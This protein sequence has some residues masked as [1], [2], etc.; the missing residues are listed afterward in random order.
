MQY[1]ASKTTEI[2]LVPMNTAAGSPHTGIPCAEK[3]SLVVALVDAASGSVVWRGW[4]TGALNHNPSEV[5]DQVKAAA[6]KLLESFP[7]PSPRL[8]LDARALAAAHARTERELVDAE[9]ADARF[10]RAGGDPERHRR[11]LRAVHAAAARGEGLLDL[12]PLVAGGGARA[13]SGGER[14]PGPSKS[15]RPRTLPRA[16]ITARSTT[17]CSSRMLPGHGYAQSAARAAFVDAPDRLADRA[18]VAADP[19]LREERDVVRPL[20]QRGH[21]DREDVEAEEE[22]G[23]ELPLARGLLQVAVGGRDHPRVRAERLAAAHPLEFAL[24]EDAQE[25]RDHRRGKLPRLVEEDRAPGC[26]PR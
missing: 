4:A 7:P 5:A 15:P 21:A 16:R 9:A 6:G 19:V 8:S 10:Q 2:G 24:L 14:R 17:F 26:T 20:P 25:G 22:V 12:P 3:G 18:R 13:G 23:A 11:A 1:H